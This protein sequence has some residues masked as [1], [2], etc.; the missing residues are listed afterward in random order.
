MDGGATKND[1]LMQIQADLLGSP[2]LRPAHQETTSLGAALAA[3]L[4][5]GF[6]T[7]DDI[8]ALT[9]DGCVGGVPAPYRPLCSLEMSSFVSRDVEFTSELPR[10]SRDKLLR[11]WHEAVKRSFGICGDSQ[12]DA[13]GH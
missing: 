9:P 5:V 6:Y 1:L 10:A 7:M 13:N 8:F 11:G 4:A 12:E 2:V 3:G